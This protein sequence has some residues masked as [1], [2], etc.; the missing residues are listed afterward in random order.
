MLPG[1]YASDDP[2]WDCPQKGKVKKFFALEFK[3]PDGS[4]MYFT[5]DFGAFALTPDVD[6][7][8]HWECG[9]EATL[10]LETLKVS[11]ANERFLKH[12]KVV[13]FGFN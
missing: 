8:V 12:L 2:I 6:A 13:P 7:A 10:A 3:F 4:A 5:D 11:L 9:E 1:P